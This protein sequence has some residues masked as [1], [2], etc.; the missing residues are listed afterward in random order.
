MCLVFEMRDRCLQL[1]VDPLQALRAIPADLD[2]RDHAFVW[3][4]C[5]YSTGW[6]G[7]LS[8]PPMDDCGG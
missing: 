8:S 3:A 4:R 1:R 2:V 5:T 6:L 7:E